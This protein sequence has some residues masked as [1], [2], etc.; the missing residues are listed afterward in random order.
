MQNNAV[1]A[2]RYHMGTIRACATRIQGI[3]QY[4]NVQKINAPRGSANPVRF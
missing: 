2:L 4:D 1:A 3:A